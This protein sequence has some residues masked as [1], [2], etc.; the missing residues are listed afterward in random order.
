MFVTNI[1]YLA[2]KSAHMQKLLFGLGLFWYSVSLAQVNQVEFGQNR[3]LYTR[4]MTD[5][6]R[7][8]STHFTIYW[9]GE[10]RQ[11]ALAAL[12]FAEADIKPVRQLLEYRVNQRFDIVV[13]ADAADLRQTRIQV[14]QALLLSQQPYLVHD[15]QILVCYDGSLEHLRTQIRAGIAKQMLNLI[16]DG[17]NFQELVTN[18]TGNVLPDWFTEGLIAFIGRGFTPDNR[19]LVNDLLYKQTPTAKT[20]NKLAVK[21]PEVMG[22]LLWSYVERKYGRQNITNILYLARINRNSKTSF[23]YVLSRPFDK[24]TRDALEDWISTHKQPALPAVTP[25]SLPKKQHWLVA[26]YVQSPRNQTAAAVY[27]NQRARVYLLNGRKWQLIKRVGLMSERPNYNGRL[28]LLAWHPDGQTLAMVTERGNTFKLS[29]Y[30]L[31]KKKWTHSELPYQ[32]QFPNHI[33]YSDP[34]TLLITSASAGVSDVF[35]YNIQL[36]QL[37]RITQDHFDDLAA[38]PGTIAKRQGLSFISNRPKPAFEA[39]T[40]QNDTFLTDLPTELFSFFY[41]DPEQRV[42]QWTNDTRKKQQL[43]RLDEYHLAYTATHDDQTQA[44]VAVIDSFI[45]FYRHRV[46]YTGGRYEEIQGD[47][48]L[49][50]PDSIAVDSMFTQPVWHLKATPYLLNHGLVNIKGMYGAACA[51]SVFLLVGLPAK[52]NKRSTTRLYKVGVELIKAPLQVLNKEIPDSVFQPETPE[53]EDF[54]SPFPKIYNIQPSTESATTTDTIPSAQLQTLPAYKF[55]PAPH[56]FRALGVSAYIP[57]F[58][59]LSAGSTIDN[60]PLFGGLQSFASTGGR[61]QQQPLSLFNK[62]RFDEILQNHLIEAGFRV[63]FAFNSFEGYVRYKDMRSRTIKQYGLYRRQATQTTG[64]NIPVSKVRQATDMV[65]AE[66]Q[67]PFDR[68]KRV[69]LHTFARQDRGIRLATD[70]TSLRAPNDNEQRMGIRTEYVYDNTE[71]L[72]PNMPTGL[73]GKVWYEGFYAFSD[74]LNRNQNRNNKTIGYLG[75]DVRA[76]QELNR[77]AIAA[78]RFAAARSFGNEGLLFM[79]GGSDGEP[80]NNQL[81]TNNPVIE[82]TYAFLA[83]APNLRGHRL[84]VRQ[85]TSYA[86]INSELR[87]A[88]IALVTGGR[89][90]NTF[91]RQLQVV[92]FFDVGTAWFG[93]TP[94]SN[95]NPA[96]TILLP[97]NPSPANPVTLEVVYSRTPFVMGTGA[98]L[99]FSLLG[100][101]IRADYAAPIRNQRLRKPIYHFAVGFDF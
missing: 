40:T 44:W 45:P 89:I 55:Q 13:Y 64:S 24:I 39:A 5:W 97:T 32:I 29:T 34:N 33:A 67:Y 72:M 84:N 30:D 53:P 78:V 16:F 70:T 21:H 38:A 74:P 27:R 69:T 12:Q 54:V 91:W 10:S 83:P 20:F 81:N 93:S 6:S 11:P 62:I 43:V 100:M 35:R 51:D 47:S 87:T 61:Y 77:Y 60:T 99:R 82:N 56:K 86:L 7:Y 8:E 79:I 50:F 80:G 46:F 23:Q 14:P 92:G 76:Y 1:D 101:Q 25:E 90:T 73:R 58:R 71:W 19:Q 36:R 94:F 52:R 66:W 18:T 96:N 26:N 28:P 48:V 42:V 85:G 37:N 2:P 75:L 65:F 98:G 22:L 59:L 31:L 49:V 95:A 63:P 17:N 9:Y 4:Q 88:P 57:A 41:N 68:F 3:V 15:N